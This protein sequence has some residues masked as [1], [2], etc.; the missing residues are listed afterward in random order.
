MIEWLGIFVPRHQRNWFFWTCWV[1][2]AI[3]VAFAIGAIVALNLACIPTKK[4]WEFWV[5]GKCI[6]AH[7]IETVSASFQLASDC[8]VLVLPQKMIWGLQLGWKKKLGVSVIFSLGV[9]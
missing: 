7:D 8:I 2:I 1:L 9:L 4:K 3:Q 5:P 6:N